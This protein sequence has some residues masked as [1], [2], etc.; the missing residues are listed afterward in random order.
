MTRI[1][2]LTDKETVNEA[3]RRRVIEL[4][5]H[6][7]TPRDIVTMMRLPLVEVDAVLEA[8]RRRKLADG[9]CVYDAFEVGSSPRPV[10]VTTARRPVIAAGKPRPRKAQPVA[11]PEPVVAA[12]PSR[13]QPPPVEPTPPPKP[14][15]VDVERARMLMQLEVLTE[16]ERKLEDELARARKQRE[17]LEA[18]LDAQECV[19]TAKLTKHRE[20]RV[21]SPEG[22]ERL[23]E[24]GR[25]QAALMRARAAAKREALA[26]TSAEL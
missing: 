9:P 15:P 10:R 25:R 4:R 18:V 17:V 13:P 6:G 14:A 11:V 21:I 26:R 16:C 3:D 22:R 23:R 20:P 5:D 8:E 1:S 12:E 24:N 2:P 19:S 7:R